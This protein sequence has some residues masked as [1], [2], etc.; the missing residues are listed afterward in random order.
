MRLHLAGILRERGK[1]DQ[2]APFYR[3]LTPPQSWYAFNT[4]RSSLELGRI[5]EERGDI[6]EALRYY[7]AAVRLW[8]FG[9][10]DVVGLWLDQAREGLARLRGERVSMN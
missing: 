6:E 8:E 9:D 4:A 7:L 3:S 5:E 2:A 1:T 10:P